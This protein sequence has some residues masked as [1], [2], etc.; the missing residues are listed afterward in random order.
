MTQPA[1]PPLDEEDQNAYNILT[2]MLNEWGLSSLA[3]DVLRL[4]QDGYSQ[5]QIPILLQDTEAYKTRFSGNQ[6][7]R[8][9]GLAV[10][11]PAEYLQVERSYRQIM[12]QAGLPEG[13]YDS[14]TDFA[15]WIGNDVAPVEVQRRVDEASDAVYRM[16]AATQQAFNE[17]YGLTAADLA[18]YI[19]DPE[20]G[21]DA[22]NRVVHG[23]RI[24][25][26]ASGYGVDL[27][28]DQAERFGGMST[29]NYLD[30]AKAFGEAAGLGQRLS[31]IYAGEDYTT[32]DA[33]S[34]VWQSSTDAVRRRRKLIAREQAEFGGRG[35]ATQNALGSGTGSY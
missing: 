14:Y 32:E 31:S 34:E 28:R 1:P 24:A 15:G 8:E 12:A 21:R 22:I 23:G 2:Q 11:S 30:E 20:R 17:F 18:A 3:P 19:L 25:G 4:L 6:A 27:T 7:R 9:K 26:A 10:L 16:D 29:Q 33:A 5:T 35:Q 13:F